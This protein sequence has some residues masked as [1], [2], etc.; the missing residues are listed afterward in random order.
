MASSAL[1]LGRGEPGPALA[2]LG[3]GALVAIA[4]ASLKA[5]VDGLAAPRTRARAVLAITG[6]YALLGF[7]AYVMIARLR[8]H[9]LWFL[10][11]ASSFVAAVSVETLRLLIR[12]H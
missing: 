8:L 3:G 1:A 5:G 12:K 7:L 11:G 9:P 10:A 6:R 4:Y 2:V